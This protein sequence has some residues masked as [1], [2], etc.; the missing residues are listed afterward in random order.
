VFYRCFPN[1]GS[2]RTAVT[3]DLQGTLC[4][5]FMPLTLLFFASNPYMFSKNQCLPASK[6]WFQ[7]RSQM[8]GG[9]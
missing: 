5:N 9:K 4:A 6:G 1:Q 2:N 7:T 8:T 3:L